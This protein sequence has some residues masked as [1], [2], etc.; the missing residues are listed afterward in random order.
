MSALPP[1]P[2]LDIT[3]RQQQVTPLNRRDPP[4]CSHHTPSPLATPQV[5]SS[6]SPTCSPPPSPPFPYRLLPFLPLMSLHCLHANWVNAAV[7]NENMC[8]VNDRFLQTSVSVHIVVRVAR[9]HLPRTTWP[10]RCFANR[11]AP[12]SAAPLLQT[13]YARLL[14][15][16]KQKSK[17]T[18]A[19]CE[20]W[21]VS[22]FLHFSIS[23]VRLMGTFM[24]RTAVPNTPVATPVSITE[25]FRAA[26]ETRAPSWRTRC[27]WCSAEPA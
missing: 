6:M 2:L 9:H 12:S 4:V 11:T 21:Y 7:K 1:S 18:H 5:L 23:G 14:C 8:F 20:A 16:S 19:E 22:P 10:L 3:T 13:S 15:I 27:R 25:P 17:A 26:P 24:A